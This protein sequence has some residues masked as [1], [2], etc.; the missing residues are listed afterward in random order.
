MLEADT[1][2]DLHYLVIP[3]RP[4]LVTLL[5]S[6]LLQVG[7][8]HNHGD[9]LID[10]HLPKVLKGYWLRSNGGD[11][12]LLDVIKLDW[13]GVDIFDWGFT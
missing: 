2:P 8:H 4:I 1:T 3:V 7:Q 12:I 10:D 5:L 11:E 13:G 9:S 6:S